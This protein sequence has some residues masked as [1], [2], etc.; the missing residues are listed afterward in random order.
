MARIVAI[1]G[2]GCE[3]YALGMGS[4]T[5]SGPDAGLAILGGGNMGRAI[6]TGVLAAGLLAREDVCVV[7]PDMM[8]HSGL[9]SCAASIETSVAALQHWLAG[10]QDACV[11]LA[12]KPQ[13]F[14]ALA[15][16]LRHAAPV[17]DRLVLSIM[18]GVSIG[19]LTRELGAPRTVRA[20]PNLPATIGQG[21]TAFSP[22]SGCTTRDRASALAV[23]G[24][25]GPVAIE[26]DESQLDLVTAVAGSGPAYL[27][28][29][30]EVM[31]ASAHRRGLSSADASALVRHTLAGAGQ[32]LI[33]DT[34]EPAELRAAVTSRGGTTHAALSVL[35]AGG[36]EALV[37]GAIGAAEARG[38]ELG[39]MQ[40]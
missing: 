1:R 39:S 8:K 40:T 15:S 23:L 29:L 3:L 24:A 33:A 6:A 17:G 5:L 21:A 2:L 35:T 36:F 16:E 27:F 20:M 28:L 10:R 34:R 25:L 26:V 9:T 4:A 19:T 22:G 31:L 14:P 30:A 38:R 37:D 12:V 11:V 18:A 13:V 7:E 32:M